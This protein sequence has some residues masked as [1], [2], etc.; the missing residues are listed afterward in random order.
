M[1]QV[2]V[3]IHRHICTLCS[4]HQYARNRINKCN[5]KCSILDNNY[6]LNFSK[7]CMTY[8]TMSIMFTSI[9]TKT[10]IIL[11]PLHSIQVAHI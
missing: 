1:K 3:S 4:H 6:I 5:K 8:H 7:K 2:F 9:M 10:A 11:S